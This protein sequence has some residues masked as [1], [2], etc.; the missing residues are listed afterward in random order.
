MQKSKK[1]N[2]TDKN[3]FPFIPPESVGG[4]ELRVSA[5]L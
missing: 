2:G 4:E 5:K 3:S 1:W